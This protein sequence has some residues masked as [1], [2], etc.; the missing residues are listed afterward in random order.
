M[1]PPVEKIRL[2]RYIRVYLS[3]TSFRRFESP[4]WTT[5]EFMFWKRRRESSV[6]LLFYYSLYSSIYSFLLL[7]FVC[8]CSFSYFL[9][10]WLE[11]LLLQSICVFWI[12][13]ILLYRGS[14]LSIVIVV[15]IVVCRCSSHSIV[16]VTVVVKT[17]I[18]VV[19]LVLLVV[20]T[21]AGDAVV[22]GQVEAIFL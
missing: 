22:A 6:L 18:N 13:T 17:S 14:S 5:A 3:V 21:V 12:L 1:V 9:S 8:T 10:C 2:V 7:L 20:V 4:S 15:I 19:K 16:R 11:V